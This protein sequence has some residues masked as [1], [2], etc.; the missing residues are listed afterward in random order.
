MNPNLQEL[1][2]RTD[3]VMAGRYR[4]NGNDQGLVHVGVDLGTA[5]TVLIVLNEKYQPIAGAYQ[6]AQVVRDG[7][8][9]DFTGAT[10]LLRKLKN[11][12]RAGWVL[13][14]SLPPAGTL[15]GCRWQRCVQ[16][17]MC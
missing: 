10:D 9:V 11:R 3:E 12:S 8:V 5:Y 7:L 2:D 6:F 15:P 16:Q 17:R 4:Q 1:L 14:S 13:S